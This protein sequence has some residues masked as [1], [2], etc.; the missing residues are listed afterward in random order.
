M[1]KKH[2]E[3]Q[4]AT[5]KVEIVEN[6]FPLIKVEDMKTEFVFWAHVSD[7]DYRAGALEWRLGDDDT[8]TINPVMSFV[9]FKNNWGFPIVNWRSAAKGYEDKGWKDW[10]DQMYRIYHADLIQSAATASAEKKQREERIL[11]VAHA[12]GGGGGGT[13]QCCFWS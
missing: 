1:V 12:Q 7:P 4:M 6:K 11:W 5:K 10:N 13:S 9:R 2:S 8:I 3:P